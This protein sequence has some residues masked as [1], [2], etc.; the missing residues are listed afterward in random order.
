MRKTRIVIFVVFLIFLSFF[1]V[2]WASDKKMNLFSKVIY[3]DP[4]HGGADS[5]AYYKNYRE[6]DIN[7]QI[8]KKL[9]DIL[10]KE[11]AIVYL[12]RYDD[13]DLSISN[14]WNRKRS[15]LSRRANII[16]K[17]KCDLY[18]SIHLNAEDSGLFRGAEVYYD[19]INAENEKIAYIFQDEFRRHL[20]SNRS[21]KENSTKYLQR[22][23]NRP[24]VL[25]E[26]GFLSNASDRALLIDA[27]YQNKIA[28][29]I[30]TGIIRYFDS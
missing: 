6:A 22:R 19:T 28:N 3:L 8:S 29:V 1:N 24:G 7:L 16:N 20:N 14:A 5:G 18:L 21:F 23:V 10:K 4:G 13:Y 2:V 26:V 11:G 9:M 12:T 25:L 27:T 30:K 17:S 15:D